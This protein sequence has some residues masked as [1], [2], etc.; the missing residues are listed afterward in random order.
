ML[1]VTNAFK[2]K[3]LFLFIF[4]L[5]LNLAE[6]YISLFIF[7]SLYISR[8]NIGDLVES[9]KL[10][11]DSELDID[12]TLLLFEEIDY[13]FNFYTNSYDFILKLRQDDYDLLDRS[14][15]IIQSNLLY[16]Q[17]YNIE[18]LKLNLNQ[19]S[20]Q[21][22]IYVRLENPDSTIDRLSDSFVFEEIITSGL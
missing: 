8:S 5:V 17:E 14:E 19:T 15:E 13:P 10:N 2:D 21:K 16:S 9:L 20:M 22:E 6:L 4:C 18:G 1:L 3:I 11:V 12:N 7:L